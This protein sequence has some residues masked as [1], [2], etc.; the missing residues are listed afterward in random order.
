MSQVADI[1]KQLMDEHKKQRADLEAKDNA[2]RFSADI[3]LT[4]DE[5]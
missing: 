4:P 5:E 2:Q 3:K 1:K